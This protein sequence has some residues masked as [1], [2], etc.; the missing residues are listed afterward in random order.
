MEKTVRKLA[1]LSLA[2]CFIGSQPSFSQAMSNSTATNPTTNG[3]ATSGS[4]MKD[5]KSTGSKMA[6]KVKHTS[7]TKRHGASHVDDNYGSNA[8]VGN[9]ASNASAEPSAN[10]AAETTT[11]P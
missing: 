2:A 4:A 1:L 6:S 5:Q 3:F 7:S 10:K 8:G 9:N 11:K